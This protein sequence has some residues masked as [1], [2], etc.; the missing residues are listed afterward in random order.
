M[1]LSIVAD[2]LPGDNEFVFRPIGVD[3]LHHFQNVSL[4]NNSLSSC[5]TLR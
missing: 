2:P 4:A 1:M 5:A 3:G